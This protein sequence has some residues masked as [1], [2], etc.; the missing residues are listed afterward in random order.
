MMNLQRQAHDTHNE[1]IVQRQGNGIKLVKPDTKSDSSNTVSSFNELPVSVYFIDINSTI[2]SANSAG[3]VLHGL[4]NAHDMHGKN[5]THFLKK[6]FSAGIFK[7]DKFVLQSEQSRIFEETGL[8]TDDAVI[9][10]VA[11]RLPW[12]HEGNLVGIFGLCADVASDGLTNFATMLTKLSSCGLLG[13]TKQTVL[14]DAFKQIDVLNYYSKREL[15]VLT[16]LM[17]GKLQ[18]KL[19]HNFSSPIELWN[20]ILSESKKRLVVIINLN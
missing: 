15:E 7:R 18:N 20:I 9:D 13:K 17:E 16:Y 1:L 8:R 12:Y 19:E 5:V 4:L 2:L 14:A 10:A 11:V 6:D 3:A